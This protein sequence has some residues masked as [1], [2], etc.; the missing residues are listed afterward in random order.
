MKIVTVLYFTLML[1]YV[2]EMSGNFTEKNMSDFLRSNSIKFFGAKVTD[3]LFFKLR[4][5]TGSID[6]LVG[7][8]TI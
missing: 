6:Q 4:V 8:A 5:T 7:E 1:Q 2:R 3:N